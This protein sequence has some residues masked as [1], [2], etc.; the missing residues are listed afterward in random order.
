TADS[1]KSVFKRAG[2][3]RTVGCLKF[4]YAYMP[5]NDLADYPAS[6]FMANTVVALKARDEMPWGNDIP[7][8]VFLHYLLPVRVNNENLDSFRILYYDELKDRIAGL[9]L[10]DAALEINRWCHEK[11]TYQPSDI[12]TSSPMATI[13]SARGRCGEESTFTV[14]ALRT[15]GIPARQV[16]TPR[17]AH[18]DDNHAWVEIWADGEWYYMGACEPE[19]VLDRGWFTEPAA[20]AMLVHTKAFGYYGGNELIVRKEK[21]Y[22]EINNLS[23]YAATKPVVVRVNDEKGLPLANATVE[24][25]LYNYAEFFPIASV[26][27]DNSGYCTF[28]TGLGNLLVWTDVGGRSGF[29]FVAVAGTDTLILVPALQPEGDIVTEADLNVPGKPEPKPGISPELADINRQL[30]A[31]GDSIRNL[32]IDS[33]IKTSAAGLFAAENGYNPDRVVPLIMKSQGNYREI[34]SFLSENKRQ[35]EMACD[36]LSQ[37]SEKDLRD[38]RSYILTAHLKAAQK[39]S[40]AYRN[41]SGEVFEK[42]VL[43]PRI[44]NEMLTDWRDLLLSVVMAGAGEPVSETGASAVS[45]LESVNRLVTLHDEENYYGTPVTPSGV[46]LTGLADTWSARIFVVACLRAAG[47][48]ARLEPG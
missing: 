48:P 13:L 47:I 1:L 10:K 36:L 33:W 16:Y 43:N 27:T 42:Y 7:E 22:A 11:V 26:K 40:D 8:D 4:L 37:L 3:S 41:T 25:C 18:T 30:I 44:A 32:Y 6:F 35:G 46:A 12:R 9:A 19:P 28:V 31:K 45:V 20:R 24:F 23:K 21:R 34:M 17:W 29:S 38:T 5:L 39:Y 14:A 15:V 2:D